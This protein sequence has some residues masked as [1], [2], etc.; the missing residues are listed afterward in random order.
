MLLRDRPAPGGCSLTNGTLQAN[1]TP[2]IRESAGTMCNAC[3]IADITRR[4]V[5]IVF[6]QSRDNDKISLL[7]R[8]Q[9]DLV[10]L[11]SG[12]TKVSHPQNN[13]LYSAKPKE[14]QALA[15][16]GPYLDTCG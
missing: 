6:C 11:S 7:V 14:T 13:L 8:L 10:T 12:F 5:V 4:S 15:P 9:L 2:P 1:G 16:R 3:P